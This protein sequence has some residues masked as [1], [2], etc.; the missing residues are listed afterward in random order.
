M[1]PR[2]DPAVYCPKGLTP[3]FL[4]GDRGPI[5]SADP[6][7]HSRQCDIAKWKNSPIAEISAIPATLAETR[8]GLNRPNRF[9][10]TTDITLTAPAGH[11]GDRAQQMPSDRLPNTGQSA[12]NHLFPQ[13]LPSQALPLQDYSLGWSPPNQ[14]QAHPARVVWESSSRESVP[15]AQIHRF[16]Q[17]PQQKGSVLFEISRKKFETILNG[18]CAIAVSPESTGN[19]SKEL[20]EIKPTESRSVTL[21]IRKNVQT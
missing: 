19:P 5:F 11:S 14:A 1:P 7:P 4:A 3:S 8:P 9:P 17:R 13:G 16:R 6:S 18:L 12:S 21:D 20:E 10:H 15:S 2:R